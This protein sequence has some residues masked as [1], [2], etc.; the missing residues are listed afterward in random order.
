MTTFI[1]NELH[2]R[3]ALN[4]N[5]AAME[6]S[7]LGLIIRRMQSKAEALIEVAPNT[8]LTPEKS[9]DHWHMATVMSVRICW[10]AKGEIENE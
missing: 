5:V 4:I 2:L 7:K 9:T 3:A 6:L 10:S 1:E 8:T